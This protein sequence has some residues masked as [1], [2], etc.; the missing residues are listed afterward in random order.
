MIREVGST[1]IN[2]FNGSFS[3][4]IAKCDNLAPALV[5]LIIEKFPG[6]RDESIVKT[7]EQIFFYK[8]AQILVGDLYA[9]LKSKDISLKNIEELTMFP[10]CRYFNHTKKI[11][12]K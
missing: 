3:S 10:D 11:S 7:G 5:D 8:R 2:I 12:I 6:F 4:I 9:A 1:V